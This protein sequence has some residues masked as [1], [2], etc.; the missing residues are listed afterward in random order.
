M[1]VPLL[2]LALTQSGGQNEGKLI[3][4]SVIA[5]T[6]KGEPVTDL[7]AG[8]IRI[9][10]DGKSRPVATLRF[11]PPSGPTVV[12]VDRWNERVATSGS[13]WTS[14]RSGLQAVQP[15]DGVYL[16]FLDT[17]GVMGQVRPLPKPGDSRKEFEPT[18]SQLIAGFDE[19]VKAAPGFRDVDS[20]DPVLRE[21]VTFRAL[22]ALIVQMAQFPGRKNLLW[23]THGVPLTTKTLDGGF[24]DITAQLRSFGAAVAQSQ[25][26]I[27]A[28]DES[29]AGAAADPN[30]QS[31]ATLQM[32][33]ASTGG[34]W[35]QSSA[36][37]QA[38]AACLSDARNNYS[39]AY[40]S[41]FEDRK[42][43]RIHLESARKG[44]HLLT[45][46][47]YEGPAPAAP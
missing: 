10:E 12:L 25:V 19:V 29:L 13:A 20:Q 26:A 38:L 40:Y 32:L 5:T 47:G 31:R 9:K 43:H 3:T 23:V 21:T 1:V 34:R 41:P 44:V 8:D 7:A 27:Y 4:I 42:F 36:F 2:L 37:A 33:A 35:F 28:V 24:L 16:Y 30:G 18:S 45:S 17:H 14:V 22:N 11:Q 39:V 6:S 15:G 46:E